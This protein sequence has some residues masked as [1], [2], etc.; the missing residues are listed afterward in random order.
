M[1]KPSRTIKQIVHPNGAIER[2]IEVNNG[3]S[4]GNNF[5]VHLKHVKDWVR[6]NGCR[7]QNVPNPRY[8]EEMAAYKHPKAGVATYNAVMLHL[9]KG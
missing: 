6:A 7:I 3:Y 9:F 4:W 1:K 2:L 8:A 5:S